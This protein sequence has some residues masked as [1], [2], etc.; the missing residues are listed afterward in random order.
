MRKINLKIE[1]IKTQTARLWLIQPGL[2][3]LPLDKNSLLCTQTVLL[4]QNLQK[5]F[6]A[7]Q[8]KQL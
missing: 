2:H 7:P 6:E 4:E 3:N 8:T 5:Y 1:A